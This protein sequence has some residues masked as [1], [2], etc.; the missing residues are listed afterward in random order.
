[1]V[2][3]GNGVVFQAPFGAAVIN[4]DGSHG[5]QAL[6]IDHVVE[7]GRQVVTH[8]IGVSGNDYRKFG[9]RDIPSRNVD[10]DV[11]LKRAVRSRVELAFGGVHDELDHLA[12][13][14]AGP[15]SEFGRGG[16]GRPIG[17]LAIGEG[18]SPRGKVHQLGSFGDVGSGLW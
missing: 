1:H 15:F 8:A 18:L 9:T 17:I 7:D 12:F 10:A 11:T 6:V 14:N 3:G 16:I 2:F 5:G 13:G 4:H